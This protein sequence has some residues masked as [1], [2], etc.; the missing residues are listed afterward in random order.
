MTNDELVERAE[1]FIHWQQ[2]RHS[3]NGWPFE[4]AQKLAAE[5]AK[6]R[7][8]ALQEAALLAPHDIRKAI[9]ALAQSGGGK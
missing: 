4:D 6:V 2:N 5:F 3:R 9:R 7:E 1:K 8:E